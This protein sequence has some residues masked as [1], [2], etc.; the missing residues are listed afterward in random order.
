MNYI[1]AFVHRK[2]KIYDILFFLVNVE[3][4]VNHLQHLDRLK[5][6]KEITKDLW[7]IKH[8]LVEAKIKITTKMC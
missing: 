6:K 3:T 4:I 8:E 1:F 7:G 2:L 5:I